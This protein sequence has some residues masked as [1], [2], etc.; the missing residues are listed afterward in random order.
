MGDYIQS[1]EKQ[2]KPLT[3]LEFTKAVR[4]LARD[5]GGDPEAYGGRCGDLMEE[6]LI[7]LEYE[8]GIKV[9]R[10]HERY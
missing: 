5:Y 10:S 7:T 8:K 2:I 6:L 1:Q 9:M 4:K 3:P